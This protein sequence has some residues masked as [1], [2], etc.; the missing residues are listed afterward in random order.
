MSVHVILS[1][2]PTFASF[3]LKR[4]SRYFE[5]S[6]LI[7][8]ISLNKLFSFMSIKISHFNSKKVKRKEAEKKNR[9]REERN[10]FLEERSCFVHEGRE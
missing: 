3:Y 1:L 8:R 6:E 10:P 4:P 9:E 5:N 7:E 2:C